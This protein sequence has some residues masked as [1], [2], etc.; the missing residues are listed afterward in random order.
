MV[1]GHAYGILDGLCL[2]VGGQCHTKLIKMRNP[3][4]ISKYDGP[5]SEKSSEWTEEFKK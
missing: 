3:W 2:T 5:W 4:G 1:S